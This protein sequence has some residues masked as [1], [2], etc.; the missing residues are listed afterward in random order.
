M[1]VQLT[2]VQDPYGTIVIRSLA[3]FLR[4]NRNRSEDPALEYKQWNSWV[5]Q[6][7][8]IVTAL[9]GCALSTAQ[10]NTYSGD[11]LANYYIW[12][13]STG[14]VVRFQ[15]SVSPSGKCSLL[16]RDTIATELGYFTAHPDY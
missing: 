8:R 9:Q 16:H 2:L 10:V 7:E 3:E 15:V 4:M 6:E 13:E 12:F 1:F 5:D 14:N 11:V